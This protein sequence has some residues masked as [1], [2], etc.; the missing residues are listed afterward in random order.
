[1]AQ[2]IKKIQGMREWKFDRDEM[3]LINWTE[4][5]GRPPIITTSK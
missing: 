2:G 4:E 3:T 5:S 1:M